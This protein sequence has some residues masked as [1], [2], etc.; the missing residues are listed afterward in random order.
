MLPTNQIFYF[1]SFMLLFGALNAKLKTVQYALHKAASRAAV[2]T[3]PW[4]PASTSFSPGDL[5]LHLIMLHIAGVGGKE[6]IESRIMLFLIIG[7][8]STMVIK[9]MWDL[10]FGVIMILLTNV[11]WRLIIDKERFTHMLR[12]RFDE[13]KRYPGPFTMMMIGIKDYDKLVKNA[14]SRSD[15]HAEKVI[16]FIN[17]SVRTVDNRGPDR[18]GP[19]HRGP[20][21][22]IRSG[23]ENPR[24][25]DPAD[26]P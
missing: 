19:V 16:D 12:L 2:P 22:Y 6:D 3:K 5:R 7:I 11:D 25:T 1:V 18:T 17:R 15:R 26:R 9:Q 10:F 13:S 23:G 24:R 8:F 20:A 14:R 4:R 21:P